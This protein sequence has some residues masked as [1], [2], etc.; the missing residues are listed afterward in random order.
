MSFV[1]NTIRLV[2]LIIFPKCAL[3]CVVK[4]CQDRTNYKLGIVAVYQQMTVWDA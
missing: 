2:E 4:Q 3:W 1:L